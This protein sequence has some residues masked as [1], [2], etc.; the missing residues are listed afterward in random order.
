MVFAAGM[1]LGLAVGAGLT[2]LVAPRSGEETRHALARRGRR[3]RARGRDAWDDLRDEL[4]DVVHR[5]RLARQ[6]RKLEDERDA[7]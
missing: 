3:L 7:S 2:L 5:R 6:C 1:L 4:H